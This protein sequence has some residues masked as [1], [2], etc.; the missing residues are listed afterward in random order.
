MNEP[1]AELSPQPSTSFIELLVN[2]SIDDSSSSGGSESSLRRQ[3]N[4]EH[5]EQHWNQTLEWLTAL[6]MKYDSPNVVLHNNLE[7]E[8]EEMVYSI[9]GSM[10]NHHNLTEEKIKV[11]ISTLKTI[12]SSSSNDHSQDFNKV[13]L[14]ERTLRLLERYW[15]SLYKY[16]TIVESCLLGYITDASSID[17]QQRA[18]QMIDQIADKKQTNEKSDVQLRWFA[19]TASREYYF[20]DVLNTVFKE[21]W[22]STSF[23]RPVLLVDDII[24]ERSV[25]ILSKGSPQSLFSSLKLIHP[26]KFRIM[27]SRLLPIVINKIK[28][29]GYDRL[30][31]IV[32]FVMGVG[33]IV[34]MKYFNKYLF[35]LFQYF[36]TVDDASSL[37]RGV[38]DLFLQL[39]HAYAPSQMSLYMP[40]ILKL[41][42]KYI[43]TKEQFILVDFIPYMHPSYF[44]NNINKQMYKMLETNRWFDP[45][46]TVKIL[47]SLLDNHLV[48]NSQTLFYNCTKIIYQQCL[49]NA[50]YTHQHSHYLKR[51]IE[52][53]DISSPSG[54]NSNILV[55]SLD[56]TIELLGYY[57]RLDQQIYSFWFEELLDMQS[58]NNND[59]GLAEITQALI[60]NHTIVSFLLSP[61]INQLSSSSSHQIIIDP[62]IYHTR[63]TLS[64]LESLVHQPAPRL[65]QPLLSSKQ[66]LLQLLNK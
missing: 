50:K 23:Q 39:C 25:T 57:L 61:H 12:S 55:L 58:K 29:N 52:L 19:L 38:I 28:D 1:P 21:Y 10:L 5:V 26:N 64:K 20:F 11:L 13:L 63:S 45:W 56:S 66:Q 59:F 49:G 3:F 18:I 54:S 32:R 33:A 46:I 24:I 17:M 30:N 35:Q 41:H 51:V 16:K 27:S 42:E 9:F 31:E 22:D 6:S 7:S 40:I 43:Q 34:G 4:E 8:T 48:E 14:R 62:F 36:K 60:D 37:D 44:A 53:V 2:L 47:Q 65:I 15:Q